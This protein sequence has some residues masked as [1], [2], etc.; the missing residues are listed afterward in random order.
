MLTVADCLNL[1]ELSQARW[2]GGT[3][4]ANREVLFA[5]VVEEPD[6]DPWIGEG[7]VI[8]TTGRHFTESQTC[9]EWMEQLARRSAACLMVACGRYIPRVPDEMIQLAD[10]YKIPVIELPWEIPFISIT[11]SIHRLIVAEQISTL[12]RLADVQNLITETALSARSIA[13][14]LQEFSRLMDRPIRIINSS[15][16]LPYPTF[17]VPAFSGHVIDMGS[18]GTDLDIQVGHQIATVTALFLLKEQVTRQ[19]EWEAR[20]HFISQFLTD[21]SSIANLSWDQSESREFHVSH[22]HYIAAISIPTPTKSKSQPGINPEFSRFRDVIWNVL[23]PLNPFLTLAKPRNCLVAVIDGTDF[24]ATS[25]TQQLHRLIQRFPNEAAV[26]SDL[27]PVE[28]LPQTYQTCIK[29]LAFAPPG[30]VS[31]TSTLLYPMVV[32]LLPQKEMAMFVHRTWDKLGNA[33]L[34]DTLA[35]WLKEGGDTSKVI[36]KLGIHRNTLNNR[37]RAIEKAM[38]MPLNPQT[39]NQLMLARDWI[40]SMA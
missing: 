6:L 24:D 27:V 32:A 2:L 20:S 36:D 28:E 8:L 16:T 14:L 29:L 18:V 7:L 13:E 19:M 33:K 39:V 3:A 4:G 35:V 26:L 30:M 9:Q 25:I 23:Q 31:P 38:E 21:E 12:R 1:P 10:S 22:S 37:L 34:R 15:A 5:H 11:T 17:P 40:D